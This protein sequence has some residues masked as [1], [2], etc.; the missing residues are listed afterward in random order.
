MVT[1]TLSGALI[2]L[3]LTAPFLSALCGTCVSDQ[4]P[5]G[6]MAAMQSGDSA[7]QLDESAENRAASATANPAASATTNHCQ[8]AAEKHQDETTDQTIIASAN[9][10]CCAMETTTD[11]EMSAVPA[12]SSSLDVAWQLTD[13]LSTAAGALLHDDIRNR[14]S[15]PP[16]L[17]APQP[18]YTLH[19][20][21]LI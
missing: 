11:F 8:K 17:P 7:H 6:I 15:K 13:S 14:R 1:R 19:S 2:V 16:P 3:F 4:C 20:A 9:A 12:V 10:G 5:F 21:F 18:L